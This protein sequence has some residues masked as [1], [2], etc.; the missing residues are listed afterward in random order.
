MSLELLDSLAI[1]T[2]AILVG[3][4]VISKVPATTSE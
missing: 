1:F 2:L 3:F 4:E